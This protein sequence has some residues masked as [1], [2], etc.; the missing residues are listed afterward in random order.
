MWPT[1]IPNRH[2]EVLQEKGLEKA[3]EIAT[4]LVALSRAVSMPCFS[5]TLEGAASISSQK[6]EKTFD[7]PLKTN[8]GSREKLNAMGRRPSH[9][10]HLVPMCS[11]PHNTAGD[12]T[13]DQ[14]SPARRS[15]P[16]ESRRGGL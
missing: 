11:V 1:L 7:Q 14:A 2:K 10:P 15:T 5:V 16:P 8:P 3:I 6:P 4:Q 13:R 9:R 12:L